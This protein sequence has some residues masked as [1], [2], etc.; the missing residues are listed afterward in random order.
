MASST[1]SP[2]PSYVDGVD[3]AAR[4]TVEGGQ[5]VV[6]DAPEELDPLAA[7]A[8]VAPAGVARDAQLA[9]EA[10]AAEALDEQGRFLR[11]SSVATAST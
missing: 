3:E 10:R 6:V 5:L 2:N 4:A 1:G 8:H 7:D 11:G 9:V